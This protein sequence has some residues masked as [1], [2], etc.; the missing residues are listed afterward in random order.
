MKFTLSWLKEH[1]E[2]EAT[3]AEIAEKLT[4]IGLE[5]EEVHDPAVALAPF[6]VAYVVEAVKHPDADKLKV[7]KVDTGNGI[8][9]V[10]CGAPNARTGLKGI[11]APEG[12]YVPG[13]DLLLKKTKI[14]GVESC[15]MLCSARELELG[16]DHEGIIDL[17]ED[18]PIGASAADVLNLDTVFDIAITPNR[19]DC[20]GVYG[21]A[22]D[23]A[24]AGLGV[25]K[26]P[27]VEQGVETVVGKGACPITI[28]LEFAPG[29]EDACL[30]FAGRVV[31]GVSN[32][33]SP[34]WLQDRLVAIG[35]RPISALVDITNYISF[36]RGRPLHVYDAD[37]IS[38]RI[39]ARLGKPGEKLEA[40]DEKTYELTADVCAIADDSGA[41][42]LGGVMGGLSTGSTDATTNVFI[43][44][45]Y[46]NPSR[47][48]QTGRALGIESDARYRF[49]RGVDPAFVGLGLELATQMVLEICGGEAS[50]VMVVGEAP[51]AQ[52]QLE[53]DPK[54][55]LRL[56][57][58]MPEESE[59]IR[60]LTELGFAPEKAGVNLKL[61]VPTWRPDI[62]GSADITEEIVRIHG[63][64]K[65]PST[66]MERPS[67]SAGAI[68]TPLQKRVRK[69]KRVLASRGLTEAVLWSFIP[70]AQAELFGGANQ[71]VVLENPI[72][73]EM[74]TMRPSLLAGLLEAVQ[75]NSDRGHSPILL[76][77]VGQQW[78]GDGEKEQ[79]IVATLVRHGSLPRHWAGA[80]SAAD[81][82]AAKADAMALLTSLGV[83]A[84]LQV[85]ADAP[86]WYHPGRSGALRLGPKNVLGYFGE[87]HPRILK[88]FDITGPVVAAEVFVQAVPE[89]K[90]KA[91]KA[92]PK[93]EHLDLLP[94]SR[95]FAFLVDEAVAAAD[96]ARAA[97]GADKVLITDVG[98]FD[99]YTG[100]GVA[101]GKKSVAIEVALQPRDK[102]LTEAEIEALSQRI[103]GAVAKA[104]GGSLRT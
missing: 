30:V 76:F 19:P 13:T 25:L 85:S 74:D 28:G 41:I 94:L 46:F 88:A 2:T 98:V 50:E 12:T 7:C 95:D 40:L 73:T 54:Q 104:T 79:D 91:T 37:K 31:R 80:Q 42:G 58:V 17:P 39:F 15:G 75:K 33:P 102:T 16:D 70:Q 49:E 11:F 90:A 10:V 3:V 69:A 62:E 96:V 9:Q 97:K 87:I 78:R 26:H 57:G 61:I 35:L 52:K 84:S 6:K 55:T 100:E 34:Q 81:I 44:S 67:I 45:A 48:A 24:A 51:T 101:V 93:L 32:G 60:I 63:L 92:K 64:D 8:V 43:E 103:I 20:L 18:A 36:D 38:G 59:T 29:T 89:A 4:A 56:T 68:L 83:P 99:I 47:T 66:P 77:E 1:L 23:L 27:G 21:V 22:R 71:A 14:R 65:V 86:A 82:Y 5:V 72:S 53:F